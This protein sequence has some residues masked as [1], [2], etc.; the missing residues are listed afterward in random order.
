MT[1]TDLAALLL[2]RLQALE[3]M[4]FVKEEAS[5]EFAIQ[6]GLSH[7]EEWLKAA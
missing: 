6:Q 2:T 3:E 7:P 4:G 1:P 5:Q